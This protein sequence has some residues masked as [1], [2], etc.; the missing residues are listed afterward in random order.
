MTWKQGKQDFDFRIKEKRGHQRHQEAKRSA[1]RLASSG[2]PGSV[3]HPHT[4]TDTRSPDLQV[5]AARTPVDQRRTPGALRRR[6]SAQ[7]SIPSTSLLPFFPRKICCTH[8]LSRHHRCSSFF[9]EARLPKREKLQNRERKR[10]FC[11]AKAAHL[12]EAS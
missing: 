8:S 1:S 6:S 5:T 7:E 2:N 3:Y 11:C 4:H 12:R 9:I 10:V